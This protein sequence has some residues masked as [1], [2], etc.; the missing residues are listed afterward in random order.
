MKNIE[1]LAKK[2]KVKMHDRFIKEK[3]AI[4]E[5]EKHAHHQSKHKDHHK[6]RKDSDYE[7]QNDYFKEQYSKSKSNHEQPEVR[8]RVQAGPKEE[9]IHASHI[10]PVLYN[11]PNADKEVLNLVDS[12]FGQGFLELN[13]DDD[14]PETQVKKPLSNPGKKVQKQDQFDFGGPKSVKNP[15]QSP[16]NFCLTSRKVRIRQLRESVFDCSQQ[17]EQ[18]ADIR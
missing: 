14:E 18:A 6:P 10:D 12:Q 7:R 17:K 1:S 2:T 3:E 4:D 13:F 15:K 16:G 11:N 8:R 9:Q 5:E